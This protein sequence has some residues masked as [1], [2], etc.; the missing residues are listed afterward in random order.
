M[1]ARKPLRASLRSRV[2]ARL[3][4]LLT[5]QGAAGFRHFHRG[6]K[7]PGGGGP[8]RTF[9]QR[10]SMNIHRALGLLFVLF[11]VATV[12]FAFSPRHGE[13]LP[14]TE[15]RIAQMLMLGAAQADG[16]LLAAGER[17]RIFVSADGGASWSAAAS[18]TEATLTALSFADERHGVAVGHDAV[19]LR[20]DDGGASWRKVAE[21]PAAEAPLL[22]VRLDASGRG[23]AAGAYGSFLVTEDGGDS[24]TAQTVA[25]D[26]RHFNAIAQLADGSLLLAGEAGLLMRSDDGGETWDMLDSPYNGSFFG[27][28]TLSDDVVL[29]YGMRGHIFRSTDRGEHWDEIASGTE[30]TLFG[31][32]RLADG[33]VVLAG[34]AGTVLLGDA[35]GEG[36]EPL[37]N[38]DTAMYA[39]VLAQRDELLLFGEGG[40][41]R[42]ALAPGG[43]Q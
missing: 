12:S 15:I 22:A 26:D 24:W 17:G 25:E 9:P 14:V 6:G 2:G 37:P 31:G 27:L 43:A 21:D 29:A 20:T 41:R 40:V 34:Q 42:V 28:L 18:P 13:P 11:V 23:W 7:P 10:A 3:R 5:G 38:G 35:R 39:A 1:H 19:I 32:H 30:A 33:R 8:A 4:T 36:F 16:R